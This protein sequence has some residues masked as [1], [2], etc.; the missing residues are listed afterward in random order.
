[1]RSLSL[2][3]PIDPV[4]QGRPRATVI[5]RKRDGL[6][7]VSIYDP[8]ECAKYKKQVRELAAILLKKQFA[9]WQ[10]LDGVLSISLTFYLP[11][12]REMGDEKKI[13]FSK[14]TYPIARADIDN[15]I[16]SAIDG[17]TG[18]LWDDDKCI[19]EISRARKLWADAQESGFEIEVRPYGQDEFNAPQESLLESKEA[20]D[21]TQ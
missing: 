17:L 5:H 15:L 1:M 13:A 3:I 16:K 7:F 19:I 12:T 18:V 9:K 11:R 6:P 10:P 2:F 21:E 4:A 20:F 8:P 14:G